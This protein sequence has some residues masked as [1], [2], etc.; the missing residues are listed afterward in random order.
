MLR[1]INYIKK[2]KNEFHVSKSTEIIK[3]N[4]QNCCVREC[5]GQQPAVSGVQLF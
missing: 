5:K 3:K 1:K 4:L 2:N